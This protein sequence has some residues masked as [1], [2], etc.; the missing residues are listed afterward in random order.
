MRAAIAKLP[1]G[2]Y[3]H[4]FQTDGLE[5][6]F[7]YNIAVNGGRAIGSASTTRA[8]RRRSTAPSTAP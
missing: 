7:T 4:A 8:P 5:E 1:D 6:P 3:T 2:T